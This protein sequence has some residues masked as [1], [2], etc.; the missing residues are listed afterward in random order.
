MITERIETLNRLAIDKDYKKLLVMLNPFIYKLVNR[1]YKDHPEIEKDLVQCGRIGLFIAMEKFDPE[2]SSNFFSFAHTYI[3]RE[4]TNFMNN[5]TRTIKIPVQQLYV[6][7]AQHRPELPTR[8]ETVST[9]TPIEDSNDTLGDTLES[10][11]Y[12]PPEQDDSDQLNLARLRHYICELKPR[13]QQVI[14]MRYF[15]EKTLSEIGLQLGITKEGVRQIEL[16]AIQRLQK[17]YK[18]GNPQ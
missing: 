5:S 7:H 18:I 14:T 12:Q 13:H 6:N 17:M 11:Y 4:I 10:D 9:A 1:R 15:E 2:R 16:K 8:I 3:F